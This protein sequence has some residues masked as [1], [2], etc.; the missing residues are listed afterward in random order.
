ME[1]FVAFPDVRIHLTVNYLYNTFSEAQKILSLAPASIPEVLSFAEQERYRA[2][3]QLPQH[4][5]FHS[6]YPFIE[7]ISHWKYPEMRVFAKKTGTEAE[8]FKI[9]YFHRLFKKRERE[10]ERY[11]RW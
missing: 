3:Y 5:I 11:E 8:G 9:A 7:K 2:L 10:R 1:L 4:K 6:L